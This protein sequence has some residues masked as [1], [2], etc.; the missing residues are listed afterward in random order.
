M[1]EQRWLRQAERDLESARD[2]LATKHYEWACFQS[3]QAAEKALKAF[4]Y[5]KGF[6]AILTHSVRDLIL[7]CSKHEK[8]FSNLVRQG[9]VLDSYYIATRYPNGLVGNEIPAEYYS[10]EDAETCINYAEL[11][12]SKV[13]RFMSSSGN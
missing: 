13:K 5:S 8:D 9:K 2:S 3:Q 7:D 10:Q 1:E 4:L 12:L 6:R 11:I